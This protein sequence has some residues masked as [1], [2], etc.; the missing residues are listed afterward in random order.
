MN[1]EQLKKI[2]L[3]ALFPLLA[4]C[5]SSGPTYAP[6]NE[7]GD[8]GY[9]ERQLT[10]DRYVVEY[11]ARE[12]HLDQARDFALLRSAE[13]TLQKGNDWFQVVE[14]NTDEEDIGSARSSVAVSHPI[15]TTRTHCGLLTCRTTTDVTTVQSTVATT[16]DPRQKVTVG[17]E[18]MMGEGRKPSGGS[19]YDAS[20]I[21]DSLRSR[22]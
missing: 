3:T 4:A 5:A 1:T 14:R 13:L 12:R 11:V 6:A 15:S 17:L 22:I 21:A 16:R 9:T 8:Y 7:R 10:D 2:L 20:N 19:Y 18:I